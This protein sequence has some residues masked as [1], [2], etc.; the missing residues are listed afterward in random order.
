MEQ[1]PDDMLIHII[2]F[3][4]HVWGLFMT[5]KGLNAAIKA[6]IRGNRGQWL[7]ERLQTDSKCLNID[8]TY[9]FMIIGPNIRPIVASIPV[10]A[11][12]CPKWHPLWPRFGISAPID[13]S[14]PIIGQLEANEL[15]FVSPITLQE[16]MEKY[17][18]AILHLME[19][20]GAIEA[21]EV[22]RDQLFY[23]E[24]PL[25]AIITQMALMGR[26]A[27]LEPDEDSKM[28]ILFHFDGM[29][30]TD[31]LEAIMIYERLNPDIFISSVFTEAKVFV[32]RTDR[33]QFPKIRAKLRSIFCK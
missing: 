22:L 20:N 33:W 30:Y 7:F 21:Y 9:Q 19:T 24:V 28:L 12:F 10:E 1:L 32:S 11:L 15:P 8:L 31:K 4:G 5:S 17:N 29:N 16:F 3:V 23:S 13:I 26:E 27:L 2:T 14:W 6:I 18:H 25:A